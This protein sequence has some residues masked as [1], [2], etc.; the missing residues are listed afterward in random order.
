MNNYFKNKLLLFNK[1]YKK[2]NITTL[3]KFSRIRINKKNSKKFNLMIIQEDLISNKIIVKLI[4]KIKK[5][6]KNN[7]MDLKK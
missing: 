1:D 7:I 2:K 4:Q 5:L 6:K 3:N